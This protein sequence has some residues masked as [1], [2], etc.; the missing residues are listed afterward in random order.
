[1][2]LPCALT[3]AGS[4]PSGGAGIQAD[5]RTFAALQVYGTAAVTAV[6][7]QN[8]LG[9]RR[10]AALDPALVAD[11]ID[12]VLD[13]IPVRAIKT[14]MLGSGAVADAVAVELIKCAV[15]V[16]VDPVMQSSSGATLLDDD[17]VRV[18]R[19][20]LIP[21]ATLVTPNLAEAE[22]LCGFLVRNVDEQEQAARALVQLG[23][24]AAL[25]KG[26]HAQGDPVD[27]LFDGDAVKELVSPRIDTMHTHGTGCAL[28]AAVCACLAL[29][30]P[31]VEA[32]V[33]AH[34]Y[35]QEAIR[36]APGIGRGRGPVHHMHP[37]YPS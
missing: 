13:D 21:H 36:T 31:L 25:V 23:A 30:L 14:G 16:V 4:D 35:V 2:T 8:T 20:R 34:A 17:G 26:G 22:K 3:V 24:K 19:E 29:G 9:V 37:W 7:S 32:V 10:V 6:T 28:S 27:V 11:Q 1:M 12:A 15:P 5:L 18:L 33:R